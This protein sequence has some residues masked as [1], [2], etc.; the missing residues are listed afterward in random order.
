MR[1]TCCRVLCPSRRKC[2]AHSNDEQ[3]YG[4]LKTVCGVGKQRLQ[5]ISRVEEVLTWFEMSW[6]TPRTQEGAVG[7]MATERQDWYFT[8]KAVV[9]ANIG[10]TAP[11]VCLGLGYQYMCLVRCAAVLATEEFLDG[12]LGRSS[13]E[14]VGEAQQGL[15]VLSSESFKFSALRLRHKDHNVN[16]SLF[17]ASC[18]L[19]WVPIPPTYI[20][21]LNSELT[22]L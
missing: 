20:A 11:S 8:S 6:E 1:K 3:W 19:V 15:V 13:A 18:V 7:F 22:I 12:R 10:L 17:K 4:R 21:A 16:V 14:D 9:V 2:L 5:L